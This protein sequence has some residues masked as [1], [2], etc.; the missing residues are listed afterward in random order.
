MFLSKFFF[1]EMNVR[2]VKHKNR[3]LGTMY[4]RQRD[5]TPVFICIP[6]YFPRLSVENGGKTMKTEAVPQD[7]WYLPHD[8]GKFWKTAAKEP[9][10]FSTTSRRLKWGAFLPNEVRSL[11]R[12]WW[13]S[14]GSNK[15]INRNQRT[16]FL[17]LTYLSHGLSPKSFSL[18]L[19]C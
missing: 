12:V 8:W 6:R 15:G 10:K 7:S 5:M 18:V 13:R 19:C 16:F 1:M 2:Q 9:S 3:L 14:G 4:N 11:H 17:F